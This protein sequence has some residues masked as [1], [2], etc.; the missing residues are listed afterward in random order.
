MTMTASTD[1]AQNASAIPATKR[2]RQ[3]VRPFVFWLGPIMG[4]LL[5]FSVLPI[6]ASFFLSFFNYEILQPKEFVGIQN[7]I[8]AFDTDPAFVKT[9]WN[10]FYYSLV[11]VPL[12]MG[13]A[14]ALAYSIH[15][16]SYFKPFFRTAYFMSYIMPAA[17]IA[18]VWSFIFQASSYGLLNGVLGYFGIPAQP[19]LNSSRLVIPSII[20]I[21]VWRNLG[22][23]LVIYLAGLSGIP[24]T[25]YEAARIDGA[26]GWQMFW[27]LTWPLLSPATLF[28]AVTGFIG[29]LQVFDIPYIMTRGA[30][31]PENAS[32]MV[33]M[34]V[35]K[36]GFQEFRMGYASALAF[37]FFFIILAL[38]V[39]QL[40]FLRTKWSY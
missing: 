39:A 30:G 19:W 21:G 28:L 36:V 34:W 18:L 15:A 29:A 23:N 4:L 20:I 13:V 33:V 26:N 40:R 8:Y 16:R 17:A 27:K 11:S 38:T 5:V 2:R 14:L 37:I 25:F 24:S 10:T 6:F 35:Q 7:Y 12:G 22:Y 1:I 9:M 32:R 31:G 3:R